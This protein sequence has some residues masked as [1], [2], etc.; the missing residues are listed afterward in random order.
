MNATL[1]EALG[2]AMGYLEGTGQAYPYSQTQKTAAYAILTAWRAGATHK[3]RLA[4]CG[5][6]AALNKSENEVG[7]ASPFL[8]EGFPRWDR[9]P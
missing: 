4:N 3:I 2:I 9:A 6:R 1:D 7:E 5:I 8:P